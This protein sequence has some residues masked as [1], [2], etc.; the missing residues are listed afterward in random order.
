MLPQWNSAVEPCRVIVDPLPG[1]GEWNMAVDEALLESA[2][3]GRACTTRWYRWNQAT[4]SIGYFQRPEEVHRDQRFV[5]LPVVR[6]LTGGGAIVHDHE[7]TYS[8]TLP[9]RHPLARNVRDLYTTV[10]D[11]IIGVLAGFGFVAGL[12]GIADARRK[13]EFLCFSRSDDFDVVMGGCKI[14]G[15]AQR[16]RKGAVLQHG[17]LLLRRSAWAGEFP[18]IFDCAGHDV[19]ESD[20]VGPL[21]RAVGEVLS[22]TTVRES[23]SEDEQQRAAQLMGG[24]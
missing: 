5:G 12:R 18:G 10:H 21:S 23:L 11:A 1:T 9:A 7:V 17:S 22:P 15:S 6:R 13:G 14:L 8:C 24:D 2:V 3:A 16:R 4:L 20:L 19:S